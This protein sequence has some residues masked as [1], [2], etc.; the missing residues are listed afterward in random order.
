MPTQ[1][2]FVLY[3]LV[4]FSLAIMVRWESVRRRNGPSLKPGILVDNSAIPE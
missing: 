1:I 4:M 2:L 3:S